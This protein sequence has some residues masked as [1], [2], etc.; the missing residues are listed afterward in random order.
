[1]KHVHVPHL[2]HDVCLVPREQLRF[3]S[4]GRTFA[5]PH[6]LKGLLGAMPTPPAVFSYSKGLQYPILGNDTRGDCFYTAC[7]HAAQTWTGS[8]GAEVTFNPAAVVAR[9]LQIAGGDNGLNDALMMPEWRGGIVGPRGPHKILDEMTVNPQ[10]DASTALA[11]W[12]F[13]GLLYTASLLDAW[14]ANPKPGDVWDAV[15]T[16]DPNA[17]H[18]IHLT[19]KEAAGTY[20]LQTWGFSPCIHLTPA[21]LKV[22]DPELIVAFS[23]EMFN[24]A[25]IAPCGL[26][27]DAL[28]ALW[29]QCGG[30]AL[31]PSPFPPAPTPT[32]TPTPT[33]PPI[34]VPPAPPV[35]VP[36]AGG[37]LTAQDLANLR[38]SQGW[39]AA[40][41]AEQKP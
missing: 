11:M 13:C 7:A 28:A 24:A 26:S 16:P 36:S 9:Y 8:A 35:P 38:T 14:Y 27:Y 37:V 19:G 17:G 4:H 25:G 31:P 3:R 21:G 32:P 23:L 33:P 30:H 34:P 20:E 29:V 41:L 5:I 6:H 10:D 39:I 22:S 2:G 12:A 18:A 1:M 40:I 15:G